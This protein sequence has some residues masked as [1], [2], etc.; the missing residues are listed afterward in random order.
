M[1]Q[2]DLAPLYTFTKENLFSCPSS[3]KKTSKVLKLLLPDWFAIDTVLKSN[4]PFVLW[5][6]GDQCLLYHWLDYALNKEYESLEIYCSDRPAFIRSA[7]ENATLWPIHWTLYAVSRVDECTVDCVADHLPELLNPS[8]L[9]KSGW[10]LLEYWFLM[11]SQWLD[12]VLLGS[13]QNTSVFSLGRFCSIH[14]SVQIKQPVWIGNHVH[15]GPGSEIGPYA[16][17]GE[18]AILPGPSKVKNSVI[19]PRTFL[20]GHTELLNSYLLG[21]CLFNFNYKA[22]ISQIDTLMAGDIQSKKSV[23]RPNLYERMIA[24]LIWLRY[25]WQSLGKKYSV[26]ATFNGLCLKEGKEGPLP[27][28]RSAWLLEVVRGNMRLVGVLPRTQAQFE[29]LSRDWQD[30]LSEAPIGVFSYADINGSFSPEEEIEAVHAVYQAT[31]AQDEMVKL[32][33][34]HFKTLFLRDPDVRV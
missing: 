22:K 12:T 18:G 13:N 15:I 10:D 34:S 28:R 2:A 8:R 6:V 24:F 14:P 23:H 16:I 25:A 4:K 19:G 33:K 3:Q 32:V 26:L 31:Q 17:I 7:L 29:G 9:P 30:I 21:G 20:A 5:Q 11:Q 1:P 27:V